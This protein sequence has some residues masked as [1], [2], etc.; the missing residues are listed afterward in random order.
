MA[1]GAEKR[2][3]I[4]RLDRCGLARWWPTWLAAGGL[5]LVA[6]LLSPSYFPARSAGGLVL[7]VPF[8][9]IVVGLA[10]D[11]L[12]RG[13]IQPALNAVLSP[14]R[15]KGLRLGTVLASIGFGVS[16]LVNLTHQ[17][18]SAALEQVVFATAVGLVL[19]CRYDTSVNLWGAVILHNA[20]EAMAVAVP[21]LLVR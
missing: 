5:A 16:H 4:G 17:P 10:E 18:V 9:A 14:P 13:L 20:L 12:W 19:G 15:R 3:P 2:F 8:Q 7:L 1:G 6:N 21:L 11:L